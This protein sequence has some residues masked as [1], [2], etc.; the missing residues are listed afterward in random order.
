MPG[1]TDALDKDIERLMVID[2]Q[3]KSG[4]KSQE[5]LG[6]YMKSLISCSLRTEKRCYSDPGLNIIVEIQL[7]QVCY[8]K[9]R[10]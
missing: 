6:A 8:T 5:S 2:Y 1:V 7:V 3:F 9:I 10:A 4:Y